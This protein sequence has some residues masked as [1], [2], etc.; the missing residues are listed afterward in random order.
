MDDPQEGLK[1]AQER[2]KAA[3][4]ESSS[5][6]PP[7]DDAARELLREQRD[8]KKD[9]RMQEFLHETENTIKIFF[10]A[11]WRDKGLAWSVFFPPPSTPKT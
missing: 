1:I 3:A 9:Q 8:A 11:H 7:L 10:S 2:N 5:S 6:K 4:K